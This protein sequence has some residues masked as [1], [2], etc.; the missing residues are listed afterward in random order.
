[1]VFEILHLAAHGN[2][3]H[4]DVRNGHEDRNLQ[5]LLLEVLVLGDDLR[6][7]H[8]AVAGSEDQIGVVD[9]HPAGFAEEG[10]DEEP[11]QQQHEGAEPQQRDVRI[12]DQQ[13]VKQPPQKQ[14]DSARDADD[15]VS[16]LI[17]SITRLSLQLHHKKHIDEDE[18]R[19]K[20]HASKRSSTPP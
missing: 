15:F 13:M 6:H 18:R 7:D 3:V 19:R 11:E 17:D 12:V 20:Q 5:H 16:F 10:Y 8:A 2:P 4:V 14:A 9:A 1:M